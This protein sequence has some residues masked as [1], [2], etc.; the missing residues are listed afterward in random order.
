MT[1]IKAEEIA[2]STANTLPELLFKLGGVNVRNLTGSPDLQLDLRGFGITGDS[3]TMVLLDG[4]RMNENDL[5]AT[6]L[7]AIPLQS[8]ERIEILPGSGTVLF[9]GGATGGTINIIT[10]APVPNQNTTSLFAGYGSYNTAD[11]R[12]GGNYSGEKLGLALNVGHQESDNYRA[13]NRLRQDN[14]LGDLRY[15]D[16]DTSLSLKFG[17]DTQRLQLPGSLNEN[18]FANDPRAASTPGDW[19]AREGEFATFSF[20]R[21]LGALNIAADLGFKDNTSTA[22]FAK[23]SPTPY[24]QIQQHGVVFSPRVRYEF[25]AFGIDSLMV[26]GVDWADWNYDRPSA[27][28]P[29]AFGAPF[30]RTS[31]TQQS[32]G[33][34]VQYTGQLTQ[35]TKLTLGAREQ[36]VTDHQIADFPGFG[37][38][39]DQT[40]TQ[41][42]HA[43]E[44]A[45]S[46]AL[47]QRWQVYGKAG[48]S[49]RVANVDE[50][51]FTATGNLLKAQT[52]RN[53]EAGVEFRPQGLKLRA[54]VYQIDLDNEIYFSPI[55]IPFGGANTNLSPTR[56]SGAEVS[57]QWAVSPRVDLAG[58]FAYQVAKFR[59]GV[60]GGVDVTNKDV[61]LVPR[62]LANLRLS[63]RI[64][65]KTQFGATANFVGRQRYDNDQSN[66]FPGMMPAF[67]LL[68][69]KLSQQWREWRFSVAVNNLFDKKY[70][71]YG[72]VDL[73][74]FGTNL[75]CG[76]PTC[77]YPQA[78]RT[79]FASAEYTFK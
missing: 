33:A 73:N 62:Q 64:T 28:S 51:G 23:S 47:G 19:S 16:A 21:A 29:D 56:R 60:Y 45:L 71:N 59:T 79:L 48:T 27:S 53:K 24:L 41:T 34:Y 18:Q 55:V 9:G 57:G 52:A 54:S 6:K 69:M 13:N 26:A 63:W 67:A 46:Q 76:T 20:G 42:P 2:H 30:G 37:L 75:L 14:M 32:T 22:Y 61:P 74:L 35:T 70:F 39:T 3:N 77:V 58:G 72:A 1:V 40:Q 4:V 66:T 44:L 78:G 49:F 15:R 7:S 8:I 5:S 38:F 12:A 31:S 50:N 43:E 36:R 11:V 65:D 68:D 17:A 10:K 25:A